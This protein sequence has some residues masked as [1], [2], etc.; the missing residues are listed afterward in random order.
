[1][2]SILTA[3]IASFVISIF[4]IC[5][6]SFHEKISGDNELCGPQKFHYKLVPRIGGLSIFLGI[7]FAIIWHDQFSGSEKILKDFFICAI[8]TFLIGFTE[9]ISKKIGVRTRLLFTSMSA[10]MFIQ[11]LGAHIIKVDFAP[12]DSM[13]SLKLVSII[14]TVLTITGLANAYNIVD[15][16]HGLAAGIN[17]LSQLCIA[18]IAYLVGDHT[19]LELSL[20]MIASLIGFFILNYPFGL[21]FLGDGGAYLI[22]FWNASLCVLLTYRH[23]EIS[24]WL[25]LVINA[26]PIVETLFSIY[27]RSIL[28]KSSPGTADGLHLHSLIY[29]RIISDRKDKKLQNQKNRWIAPYF[30]G[31]GFITML[32]ALIWPKSTHILMLTFFTSF[33]IY[34]YVYRGIV[35]FQRT[36]YK[37]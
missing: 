33:A 35:R 14:F 13:L 5:T 23:S 3:F 2:E 15:G 11:M 37:K 28:K 22:G 24:P 30:W 34:L 31:M 21:I 4:I 18:Y 19:I 10:I 32:P 16:F 8:P 1:M 26:Y 27:R 20:L 29:R 9:D 36:Q 12:L 7:L 17:L 25:P 6:Q